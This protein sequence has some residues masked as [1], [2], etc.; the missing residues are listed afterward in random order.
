MKIPVDWNRSGGLSSGSTASR[1]TPGRF[2]VLKSALSITCTSRWVRE[3]GLA[4]LLLL[5]VF[6]AGPAG[7]AK[8]TAQK[9]APKP[10]AQKAAPKPADAS[11]ATKLS[12]D[13]VSLPWTG[14]FD[15]MVKRRR[16]R[17]LGVSRHQCDRVACDIIQIEGFRL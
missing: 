1:A 3:A 11:P 17:I 14:D 13:L 5:V 12:Q 6:S 4:V 8:P 2:S 9:A 16:I 15:G 7:Q 10:A